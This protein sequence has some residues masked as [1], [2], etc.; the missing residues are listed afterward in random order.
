MRV[1][2]CF[3]IAT[4]ADRYDGPMPGSC[5][6]DVCRYAAAICVI[7]RHRSQQLEL[8]RVSDEACDDLV[9][10]ISC[11]ALTKLLAWARQTEAGDR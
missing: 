1:E 9:G 10:K 11:S 7:T 5:L 2:H 8:A 4:L 6:K 3:P